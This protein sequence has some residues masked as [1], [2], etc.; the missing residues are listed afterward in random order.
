MNQTSSET[1]LK[2]GDCTS[3]LDIGFQSTHK[4]NDAT[5]HE[6]CV[7]S[8][9]YAHPAVDIAVSHFSAIQKKTIV[10][11]SDEKAE[12]AVQSTQYGI[13]GIRTPSSKEPV[14]AK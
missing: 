3:K 12:E 4:S 10:N 14:H 11:I 9:I 8:E 5:R 13:K 6:D 2:S 1:A 7:P